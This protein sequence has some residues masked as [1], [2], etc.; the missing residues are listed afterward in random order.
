MSHLKITFYHYIETI[1]D[2]DCSVNFIETSLQVSMSSKRHDI[3]FKWYAKDSF[4]IMYIV[5]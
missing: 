1:K 4:D 5:R 3:F 2:E